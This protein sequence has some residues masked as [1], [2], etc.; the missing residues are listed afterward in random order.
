MLPARLITARVC[1]AEKDEKGTKE[2][3]AAYLRGRIIQA[4]PAPS[5]REESTEVARG[6]KV[7]PDKV[8]GDTRAR[9]G[10]RKRDT[11]D[12]GIRHRRGKGANRPVTGRHPSCHG[13]SRD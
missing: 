7:R 6:S 3:E 1:E 10:L 5:L 4:T 13:A 11:R 9:R 2:K 12:A 8:F